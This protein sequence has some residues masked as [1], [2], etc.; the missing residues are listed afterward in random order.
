M[1]PTAAAA[2]VTVPVALRF[3]VVPLALV[4]FAVAVMVSEPLQPFAVYVASA[5]PV[6]VDTEPAGS[7]DPTGPTIVAV[8]AATHGELNTTVTGV[9]EYKVP[10][11][12]TIEAW[13]VAE[14]PAPSMVGVISSAPLVKEPP[15]PLPME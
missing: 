2:I 8:P 14:P 6:L 9:P 4:T 10:V 11:L 7:V 1:D 5:V 15:V 12:S 13:T 3:D